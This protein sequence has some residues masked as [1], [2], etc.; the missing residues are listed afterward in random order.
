MI[1][2]SSIQKFLQAKVLVIGDVMIDRYYL[3]DSQRI[4][5][6]AP[7]P[8]VNITAVENKAGGAANVAR[9]I[10]QL[11][12][13]TGLI[14]LVGQD[15][16]ATALASIL[17]Q[18][19]IQHHLLPLDDWP[20]IVKMRV[21]SRH[22][23]IVRMDIERQAPT[24]SSAA[25]LAALKEHLAD[26]ALVVLSDYKKGALQDIK[27][28][29]QLAKQLGKPV[30]VDPKQDDLNLYQGVDLIT[31]NLAE[32]VR[33]GGQVDSEVAMYA[34]A[35]ELLQQ[36]DIKAM[37]LTRSEQGMTL[38]TQEEAHHF[39]A[40]VLEVSDVTGA[41][42]TVIASLATALAAGIAIQEAV[43]IANIAAG[44][45]V[46][47]R[48]TSTVQPQ[49][50]MQRI[51][52]QQARNEQRK[53]IPIGLNEADKQQ[54]LQEIHAAQQA[55]E[56]I[57]FTNGCFDLLHAGHVTYLAQAKALGHRLVVGLNSDASVQ[58]LKG[59]SR[60]INSLVDRA[61]VL[62]SLASVDWVLSFGDQPDEQDTPYQ[63]IQA[64][65][66]DILVKGG[67]YQPESIVGADLV[68]QAGGRVEVLD[69]LPGRS[70]TQ[71]ISKAN[72][73]TP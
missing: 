16:D 55:G 47:K 64:V 35:R 20:T 57:V 3:G 59:N 45:V 21:L 2:T 42:D 60:P 12:A 19:K 40:Q 37:L 24:H 68:L 46:A 73:S 8:V 53:S 14:G 30:L 43:E 17:Q 11:G 5:P 29:I 23:Q 1:H 44:I 48:G 6:E 66:P 72:N 31:P 50:L 39:P 69:F 32:F 36:H 22:Q 15:Q 62:A 18:D 4:S 9:N 67:D 63:L 38:I 25:V 41:G 7:V 34:S 10:A 61:T 13:Q 28:L 70:T 27:P 71:M 56:T 33:F 58:R 52:H 65:A 26:Y 54:V 49:E 51:C